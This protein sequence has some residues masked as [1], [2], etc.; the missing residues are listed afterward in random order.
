MIWFHDEIF[1]YFDFTNFSSK[2]WFD[3]NAMRI[4]LRHEDL[5]KNFTTE[6]EKRYCQIKILKKN[7]W[8]QSIEKFRRE[9]KSLKKSW[10]QIIE[11][12]IVKSE[13]KSGE[14]LD[15]LPMFISKTLMRFIFQSD[16]NF[17]LAPCDLCYSTKNPIAEDVLKQI[18]LLLLTLIDFG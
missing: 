12:I 7:S 11:K 10:N 5:K 9:I 17:G 4:K 18:D 8:N 13:V 3:I 15:D 16:F 2:F 1:Q 6:L 14:K